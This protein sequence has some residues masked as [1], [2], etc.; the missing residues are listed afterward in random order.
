MQP[1]T[2]PL[3][4]KFLSGSSRKNK[5]RTK[6]CSAKTAP[7]IFATFAALTLAFSAVA[8]VPVT[9]KAASKNRQ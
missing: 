4:N 3:R 5:G 6:F 8:G 7:Q 1:V 2:K 9:S